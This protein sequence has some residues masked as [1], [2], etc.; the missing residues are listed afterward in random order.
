M[1]NPDRLALFLVSTADER[2]AEA[3]E[4][5]LRRLGFDVRR[6]GRTSPALVHRGKE[7]QRTIRFDSEGDAPEEA[8]PVVELDYE[9]ATFAIFN[10]VGE[11]S[12]QIEWPAPPDDGRR[13]PPPG[14]YAVIMAGVGERDSP[15]GV[16]SIELDN[17]GEWLPTVVRWLSE[18]GWTASL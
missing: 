14:A 5:V 7:T 6:T 11:A 10:I 18:M 13:L 3:L 16:G 15:E 17:E 4:R 8:G 12:P 2:V 9:N 1:E